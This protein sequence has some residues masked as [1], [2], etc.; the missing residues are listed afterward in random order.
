MLSYLT[1]YKP[2]RVPLNPR[3]LNHELRSSPELEWARKVRLAKIKPSTKTRARRCGCSRRPTAAKAAATVLV[4]AALVADVSLFVPFFVRS[5]WTA[6]AAVAVAALLSWT[7][8]DGCDVGVA[9]ASTPEL[10]T[11]RPELRIPKPEPRPLSLSPMKLGRT[12]F[13]LSS[14]RWAS[15][16]CLATGSLIVSVE[17]LYLH[18]LSQCLWGGL[19]CLAGVNPYRFPLVEPFVDTWDA[20]SWRPCTI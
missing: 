5:A 2:H 1:W 20:L 10:G 11:G 12:G 3:A 8:G 9:K 18:C 16:I 14:R 13:R 4:F 15:E 7:Y 17:F 6:V 19:W